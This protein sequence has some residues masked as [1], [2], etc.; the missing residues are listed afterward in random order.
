MTLLLARV[1]E[2]HTFSIGDLPSRAGVSLRASPKNCE[3]KW[4]ATCAEPILVATYVILA[5]AS[6]HNTVGTAVPDIPSRS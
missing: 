5:I 4:L 6:A 3:I 2:V 1:Y